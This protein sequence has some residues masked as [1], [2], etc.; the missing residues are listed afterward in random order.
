MTAATLDAL[1]AEDYDPIDHLNQIFSHPSTLSSLP[2]TRTLLTRFQDGL[3]TSIAQLSTAQAASH[4]ES[5]AQMAST[6]EELAELFEHINSVRTRAAQTQQTITAMTADIKSLDHTKRNLTH[7]MTALKRLQMLSTAYT[8]L[9]TLTKTRQ[10]RES[11]SLL[12]ATQQLA[13]HF[14]SY[15]SVDA[16]ASLARSI[17]QLQTDLLEQICEDFELCFSRDEVPSKRNML[18]EA[19]LVIDVLGDPARNRL[20][21]WYTNTSLRPYRQIFR[22]SGMDSTAATNE[23]GSLDN[24]D[25]RYKWFQKTL[26][27]Y[28]E[29]HAV[30]FPQHWRV[31][32]HL[33]N[34]FAEGTRE[35]YKS[36]LGRS[37]RVGQTLDVKLLLSCLQQTLDFE[38]SLERRF[39]IS[40]GSRA[41]I[42]T[43]TSERDG[44][45]SS[46][47][48]SGGSQPISSAFTPHLSLWVDLQDR[49]LAGL[50]PQYRL[51]PTRPP[52]ASPDEHEEFNPQ[53]VISSA[54]E[55]F[56][57]YRL[58]LAQ[59]SKLSTGEPLLQLAR[60]FA[61]YLD[62]YAQQ[63]LLSYLSE[64]PSN[65]T[66]SRRPA[67]EDIILVLNTADYCYNTTTSLSDKIN[68]RLEEPLKESI[69]LTSQADAFMGL[70]SA[71]IRAL[72]N[73]LSLTLA[74]HFSTMRHTSYSRI[75]TATST[76]P[77]LSPL[78]ETL[79]TTSTQVLT[80]LSPLKPH[81]TRAFTDALPATILESCYLATLPLCRPISEG[82]AEMML[83]DLHALK[84]TLTSLPT[85]THSRTSSSSQD[86][87]KEPPQ[88]YLKRLTASLSRIEPLLKTLQTR[89]EPAE[90]LVQAYLV[91]IADSSEANFRKVL[92]LK[93]LRRQGEQAGL[94]E[95]FN[96][97]KMSSRYG[98][99]LAERN[100]VVSGLAFS[101]AG[102]G[103]GV[104]G[105]AAGQGAGGPGDAGMS[106]G[107]G[108]GVGG[109]AG[110][111]H[112]M[113]SGVNQA[114]QTLGSSATN[115]PGTVVA[116]MK[117]INV[118]INNV[119]GLASGWMERFG[120]SRDSIGMGMGTPVAVGTPTGEVGGGGGGGGVGGGDGLPGISV[121]GT[122]AGGVGEGK[123]NENLKNIGK[124]FRRDHL[125]GLGSGLSGR[126]GGGSGAASPALGEERR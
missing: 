125:A 36:I 44:V 34:V 16:I 55:L 49:D 74:P 119:S 99:S 40:S 20:V 76:S 100:A 15:R 104:G 85:L 53:T 94:V 27:T 42:D 98:G 30:I 43:T 120:A 22:T 79:T 6:K 106:G 3:D 109:A 48:A 38:A 69:D 112:G 126:F 21:T 115:L 91:H 72:L 78:L 26:R 88:S 121:D 12:A 89:P 24:I 75:E 58:S 95:L 116:G 113:V 19:C 108:V 114:A 96:M 71:S 10:Y 9:L 46:A 97:H 65:A 1:D 50:I 111:V 61:K 67:L 39:Q 86:P 51:R 4:T 90:A 81:Y 33:A 83:L 32:E 84:N 105:G 101:A 28:E 92:E 117:D 66:P 13:T 93:G 8:Q 87:P 14:K 23:A 56:N 2:Q 25:R 52:P 63:V 123:L 57:F 107:T 118:N 11:A 122:A 68:S 103:S 29:E 59:C 41:S 45:A 60:V 80:Y 110:G 73:Y 124:F 62:M 82:G 18:H 54:S 7:S 17:A 64:R 47:F 31:G 102:T 37:T 35:D 5:L 70:A 77:F